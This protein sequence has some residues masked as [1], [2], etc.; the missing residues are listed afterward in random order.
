MAS[1]DS[2]RDREIIPR[3][4]PLDQTLRLKQ[5]DS[6]E[7][8]QA[9]REVDKD[10]VQQKLLDWQRHQ[11]VG[12]A[13]DLLGTGIALR[14]TRN[15]IDAANFLLNSGLRLSP[16]AHDLANQVL[17]QSSATEQ[18]ARLPHRPTKFDLGRAV[19]T[20]RQM[21]RSEAKDAVTW[22]ELSRIYACLGK[23]R[24]AERCMTASVQLASSSRFILR[25]AS[26]LW[27]HLDD[28]ERGYFQLV[29]SDRTRHDPWLL[30]AAIATS[31]LARKRPPHVKDARHMITS[32]RFSISQVTELASALA[33]LESRN[34][35]RKK[36]K[37]LFAKSLE[38][39]NENSLAQ[40]AWAQRQ[41][42]VNVRLDHLY[43]KVHDP[44]EAKFWYCYQGGNWEQS[45]EQCRQWSYDQPFSSR[46]YGLGSYVAGTAL[47]DYHE[48]KSF[49]ERGLLASP[50]DFTLLNNLAFAEI[51]LGN[52]AKAQYSITR[53]EQMQLS[54][55]EQVVV[56]ATMGLWHFRSNIVPAGRKYY[57]RACSNARKLKN[58]GLRSLLLGLATTFHA[59]EEIAAG[60]SSEQAVVVEAFENLKNMDDPISWALKKRLDLLTKKKEVITGS[61]NLNI[62]STRVSVK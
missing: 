46:P 21:L 50:R 47:E 58:G 30:G 41:G 7:E 29:R 27:T 59:I 1:F 53:L 16:W 49:C 48:C 13:T 55:Q 57:L 28:P 12:H 36:A 5:L 4:R 51:N 2:D 23:N 39:P 60:N 32:G 54:T 62:L 26:R 61:S 14:E 31:S 17:L 45:V 33:T 9:I 3:W 20:F 37:R 24:Q 42:Y 18:P 6:V 8:P 40:A 11:S 35:S 56:D 44:F 22:A 38:D 34:G 52:L 10:L 19:R 15:L 43:A 25:S